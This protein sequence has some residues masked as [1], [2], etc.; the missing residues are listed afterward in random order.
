[1]KQN[2]IIRFFSAIGRGFKN[3]FMFLTFSI[4]CFFIRPFAR[5]KVVGKNNVSKDDDARVF[6]ANHYE[7][8]GP[9]VIFL[10]FPYKFRPWVI[11]KMT[12]QKQVEQQMSLGIYGKFKK[13]PKWLKKIAIKILKN[14]MVYTM[15]NR[16]KAIP[17]SREN[18]RANIK[19]MQESVETLEKGKDIV[20]FPELSYVD[21]GVGE[22]QTGFE[23]LAKYYYQKTGKKITFYPIF[24]SQKNKK[25][26]IE[27][28]ITFNP[29]NDPNEEKK[30][31][32]NYLYSTMVETY[33]K[34][35]V[36]KS[37]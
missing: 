4:A 26:Y 21:E 36:E 25:M 16:A 27:K 6:I 15:N 34:Q 31:I 1:M 33:K 8:Y 13:Y 37:K 10:R 11:D 29:D 20:I 35:E 5:C 30:N 18:P 14:I 2:F 23:H 32:T 7:I 12:D 17:V 28:P 19:T 3:F 24:I 22:F 9:V